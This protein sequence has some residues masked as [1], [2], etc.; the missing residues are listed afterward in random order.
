MIMK[1]SSHQ[2][3]YGEVVVNLTYNHSDRMFDGDSQIQV[4][5]RGNGRVD[6]VVIREYDENGNLVSSESH[7]T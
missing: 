4:V 3:D 2:T 1:H 5:T 6:H 7:Y